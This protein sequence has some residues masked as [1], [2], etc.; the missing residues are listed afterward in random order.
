[1]STYAKALAEFRRHVC[2]SA[3]D[4]CACR[5]DYE[6]TRCGDV[7]Q[8]RGED[9]AD[10]AQAECQWCAGPGANEPRIAA[11]LEIARGIPTFML[12]DRR[13]ALRTGM[14]DQVF[15]DFDP[16]VPGYDCSF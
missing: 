2:T 10:S 8:V 4:V 16:P 12:Q 9:L 1:M 14:H 5:F 7:V 6:C 11:L 13:D 15:D 3:S